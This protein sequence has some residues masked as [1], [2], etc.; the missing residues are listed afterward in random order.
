M[1]SISQFIKYGDITVISNAPKKFLKE[2]N[3][4]GMVTSN[5]AIKKNVLEI[6]KETTMPLEK[7]HKALLLV[8]FDKRLL[9]LSGIDLSDLEKKKLLLAYHLL[10]NKKVLIFDHLF[11][12]C[13]YSET[14]YFK[15]LLR[16]LASKQKMAILVLE[17]DMDF[18]CEFVLKII[19]YKGNNSFQEVSDFYDENIYKYLEKP[20]TV[21]LVSSLESKG[22]FIDHEVTF[23]ETLKAIYRGVS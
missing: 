20:K 9:K 21:A 4:Y 3:D 7:I 5:F 23:S 2:A 10:T 19:L 13:I 14:Q 8:Q 17:E 1:A 22:Y 11:K 12:D 15:R 16:N 6:L 18:L